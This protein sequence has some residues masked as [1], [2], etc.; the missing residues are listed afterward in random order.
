[1]REVRDAVASFGLAAADIVASPLLGP[2]GN[3]EF[4]MRLG[5]GGEPVSDAKIDALVDEGSS[6]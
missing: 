5:R 2:A 4:L 1:L 6:P 3:R